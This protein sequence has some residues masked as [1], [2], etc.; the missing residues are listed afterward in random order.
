MGKLLD[1]AKS[2]GRKPKEHN[3]SS[4]E[5]EIALAWVRDEITMAQISR[6]LNTSYPAA[7]AKMANCLKT[8]YRAGILKLA[9]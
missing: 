9:K 2:L 1:K 5:I 7:A 4:D 6:A 3:V 8:A